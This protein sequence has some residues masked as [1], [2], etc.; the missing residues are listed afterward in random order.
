MLIVKSKVMIGELAEAFKRNY[1]HYYN[2]GRETTYH[3]LYV[4]R[5]R[6]I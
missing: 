1:N 4:I 5:P 2:L 3:D 6:N